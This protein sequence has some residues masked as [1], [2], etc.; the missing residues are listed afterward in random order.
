MT[1]VILCWK[2]HPAAETLENTMSDT[3]YRCK[4]LEGHTG[5]HCNSYGDQWANTATEDHRQH[6]E[7]VKAASQTTVSLADVPGLVKRILYNQAAAKAAEL[8]TREDIEKL[9]NKRRQAKREKRFADA[10]AIRAQLEAVGY[11]AVGRDNAECPPAPYRP[12][13]SKGKWPL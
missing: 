1:H 11:D 2:K 12:K 8:A 4:R 7:R 10:D 13:L 3:S 5:D 6:V 9:W